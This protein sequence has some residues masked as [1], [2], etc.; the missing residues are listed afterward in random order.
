MAEKMIFRPN[1]ISADEWGKLTKEEQ[2]R[3]WKEWRERQPE[4]SPEEH[5]R[6]IL[7]EWKRGVLRDHEAVEYIFDKVPVECDWLFRQIPPEFETVVKKTVDQHPLC[8]W[9]ELRLRG[10]RSYCR[11]GYKAHRSDHLTSHSANYESWITRM[12]DYYLAKGERLGRREQLPRLEM[13]LEEIVVLEDG[14]MRQRPPHRLSE[15]V[16]LHILGWRKLDEEHWEH[17]TF[18]RG[19][20]E[21][22]KTCDP[23]FFQD[24][25]VTGD[26][27]VGMLWEKLRNFHPWVYRDSHGKATRWADVCLSDY[28]ACDHASQSPMKA[29]SEPSV[30]VLRQDGN[31]NIPSHLRPSEDK[32]GYFDFDD[33]DLCSAIRSGRSFR[34]VGFRFQEALCR[35]LLIAK[36][37]RQDDLGPS[38]EPVVP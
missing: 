38:G 3:W 14:L 25:N 15:S 17:F 30:V 5:V 26:P 1:G 28:M 11:P 37:C 10:L 32:E 36:K 16:A 6:M 19:E 12:R 31:L 29:N 33:A 21:G 24:F 22:W 2:L 20:G 9:E 27:T 13:S 18:T 23:P 8:P 4:R 35:A 7:K 34:V